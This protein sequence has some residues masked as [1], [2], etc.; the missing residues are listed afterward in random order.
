MDRLGI[1]ERGI[2]RRNSPAEKVVRTALAVIIPTVLRWLI[3]RGA[4]GTT[5]VIYLP[6]ILMIAVYLGRKWGFLAIAG[7]VVAV[8]FV[9]P[10]LLAASLVWAYAVS[11]VLFVAS[12]V[13]MVVIGDSLRNAVMELQERTR[14]A[15][16]FNQE[17]QH[18]T[19][20]A[21]QM[22]RALASRATG[23]TDPAA[24]YESL[25]GRL[26][27]LAKANELLR[28]GALEACELREL[29][30]AAIKPFNARQIELDGP[31]V[32]ISRDACTPLMMALHELCT[33]ATKYGAL[34]CPEGSVEIRWDT[35]EGGD[36]VEFEWA[37]SGGPPVEQP[38]SKG[39]GMR[40]LVANGGMK[41]VSLRFRPQGVRCRITVD[42]RD[43]Q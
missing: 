26:G 3:D 14:Q 12:S 9:L 19:K 40:L 6:A 41:A 37:E 42:T 32:A 29:V 13:L 5:L 16:A 7:S 24:F 10:P 36:C 31:D 34:S 4:Y 18:R 17:L 1:V 28:F 30:D 39:L 11:M 15:E 38:K 27:A 33:N 20:N 8:V 2:L 21:L 35:G 22:M 23:A 43:A 25:S